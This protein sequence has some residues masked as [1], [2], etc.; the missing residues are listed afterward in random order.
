MEAIKVAVIGYGHLG[1]WHATKVEKTGLAKLVA[2]VESFPP[3]QQL[4]KNA[5][6]NTLIVSS[7]EEIIDQIDAAII[8]TP[9]SVHATLVKYLISKNKHVFCEKP[10]TSELKDALDIEKNINDQKLILQVGHSERFHQ[11]WEI[12]HSKYKNYLEAPLVGRISRYA[13]FKGRATDVDV[14]SDVM[15][16]DMDLMVYLI[17]EKPL[18][19]ESFGQKIRTTKWDHALCNFHFKSGTFISILSSRNHVTEIREVEL[20]SKVGTI[21]IDLMKCEISIAPKDQISEGV[22]VEKFTYEKR[23]HLQLEHEAFYNAILGKSKV[24]VNVHDGVYAVKMIDCALKSLEN[25]SKVSL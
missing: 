22:F 9:T 6:P 1:K 19:V 15:I 13:P 5:H 12:I 16:H 8:V 3:N 4:A 21:F 20:T 2:I 25:S 17:G 23:D 11:A 14:I 10:L 24:P 18:T 7:I